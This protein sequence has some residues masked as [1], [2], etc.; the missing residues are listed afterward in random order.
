VIGW[1]VGVVVAYMPMVGG[2]GGVE[3][4]QIII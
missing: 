3:L 2:L 1:L 4:L